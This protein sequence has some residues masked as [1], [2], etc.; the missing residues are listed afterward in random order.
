[1]LYHTVKSLVVALAFGATAASAQNPV[2]SLVSRR[3][4]EYLMPATTETHEFARVPNTNFVLLTQM[5]DS[6]LIK[7]ELDPTTEE[8]IAYHS[9]PMGKN[10]S[11]QL[12]GVWPSTVH[13]GMMWLSLQA[14]NKLLLVDPGQ[15]LS[16]EPSIIQTIDIPAP[17]NGP[18]CVFEIGNRVWAGLKVASKQ[19]GQYYVFSADV[20]NSTDQKLYQCLNSPVFIKEEPTTGLIYVTQDNDSSIMRINVTSGETTQLPIPPSVGNNAVGMTT[21]YGSM[22][23]VWFTLAGNA[24]G[25]TGTFGH[26]GSSGE[27]EFFKLEHPLLGTNAGLLHVADASTEAGGP[28]LWLLSTS[29]LSTN[30]PD[31]LI[32]VNFD[33]GVTS[34]SGEEYIS[35]PTQNAMVHR[36]LPLDKT[37][38]VSELHTFTLAQLTYNNTI[39]GQWLPAEAVSNTT[40][41]TEAG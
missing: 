34:I 10:S 37:V 38:L 18:H 32:R 4:T 27:M 25:G 41:Y 20:S 36:V 24:T 28:A 40:V 11:S 21:A 3:V 19:T 9:F 35:M 23:G 22:S 1:M 14:D 7:I 2:T 8:P 33:A 13:P 39:A 16:T 30:S 15:D 12:H 6:E 29:L 5:S 26:I 17:G 31:A